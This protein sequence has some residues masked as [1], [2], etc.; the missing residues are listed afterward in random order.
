MLTVVLTAMLTSGQALAVAIASRVV[1]IFFDVLLALMASLLRNRR[2]RG[3]TVEPADSG[4]LS[5]P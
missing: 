4:E 1:L 3:G 2:T 5:R